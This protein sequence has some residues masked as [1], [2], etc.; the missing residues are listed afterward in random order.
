MRKDGM[1]ELLTDWTA[2][3]RRP[4]TFADWFIEAVTA[5][6]LH[7]VPNRPWRFTTILDAEQSSTTS[8][9]RSSANTLG[10]TAQGRL[11]NPRLAQ[12]STVWS[13]LRHVA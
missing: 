13:E 10:F 3:T 5:G 9:R 11:G 6:Q 4:T 1:D 8:S 12:S 2:A 7:Q